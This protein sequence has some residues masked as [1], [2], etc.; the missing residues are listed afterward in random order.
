MEIYASV[1]ETSSGWTAVQRFLARE[2]NI[3]PEDLSPHLYC[4]EGHMAARHLMRVAAGLDSMILGEPQILGQVSRA[5]SEA[6]GSGTAGPVLSSLFMKAAHAGKRAR[7]KPQSAV[8]RR[9]SV[10]RR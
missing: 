7:W 1:A 3:L 2:H 4:L 9:R 5:F 6:R 8:T 10:T